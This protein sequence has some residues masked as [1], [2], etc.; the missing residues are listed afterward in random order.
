MRWYWS[1][2]SLAL[3]HQCGHKDEINA[4]SCWYNHINNM[5]HSTTKLRQYLTWFAAQNK[6][7]KGFLTQMTLSNNKDVLF[8]C[9]R[10]YS[11][12]CWKCI[13]LFHYFAM[14]LV[15]VWYSFK[16]ELPISVSQYS[17]W[18][19]AFRTNPIHGITNMHVENIYFK[20][21]IFLQHEMASTGGIY[22]YFEMIC[23]MSFTLATMIIKY[24]WVL[25]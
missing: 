15:T 4:L 3:S 10:Y 21:N 22:I 19:M 9:Q 12:S 13:I 7:C 24:Q 16:W 1:Y 14:G 25:L 20:C 5:H 23:N 6:L 17:Y 11:M 2:C 18:L 8:R